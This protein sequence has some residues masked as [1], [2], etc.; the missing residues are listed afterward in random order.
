MSA[1]QPM[2]R[3]TR[4]NDIIKR[5]GGREELLRPCTKQRRIEI[6]SRQ[7]RRKLFKALSGKPDGTLVE[8]DGK[9]YR[10]SRIDTM[11]Q[12]I[13]FFEKTNLPI[14]QADDLVNELEE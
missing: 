4:Y 2:H 13:L 3:T 11:Q 12:L 14:I 9:L 1:N 10:Y 6:L 7:Y 5:V 8:W